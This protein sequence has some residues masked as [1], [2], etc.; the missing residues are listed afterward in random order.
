VAIDCNNPVIKLCIEGTHSEFEGRKEDACDLYRQ[1]WEAA[2]DDYEACI[3]AHY[4][5]RCQDSPEEIL[6]WNQLA[7][8]RADAVKDECVKD[9]YPSLFLSMGRSYELL[10]DQTGAK[11]YYHRAAKPG[12][13][14][15]ME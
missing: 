2:T 5:A 7:L 4:I 9:F 8:E 6:R 15:Q 1:A 12:V 14:H 10:G 3:A 11:K 13:T